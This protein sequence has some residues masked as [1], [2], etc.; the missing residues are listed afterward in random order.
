MQ[1][2]WKKEKVVFEYE[3]RIGMRDVDAGGVLFFARYLSLVHEATEAMFARQ[4][5]HFMGHVAEHG[6]VFPVVHVRADYR[7]PLPIGETATIQ[8][9]VSEIKRRTYTIAFTFLV[10]GQ[11]AANGELVHACVDCATR[12][13]TPLP[14]QVIE[15]LQACC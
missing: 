10:Q 1:N 13:A 7:M 5:I 6:V 12:K 11:I 8:L 15:I 4:G 3:R 14:P 2:L 9:N